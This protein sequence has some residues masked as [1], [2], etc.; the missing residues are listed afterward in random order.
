MTELS[1]K[2]ETLS[3]LQTRLKQ[4]K[5]LPQQFFTVQQWKNNPTSILKSAKSFFQNLPLIVRSSSL[6]EDTGSSSAAGAYKTLKDISHRQLSDAINEVI[7]SYDDT[8]VLN[9]ILLQ[10]MLKDVVLSGAAFSHDPNNGS[11]YLIVNWYVGSDTSFVT[12][13]QGGHIWRQAQCA[14]VDAPESISPVILLLK[15]LDKIFKQTPLDIEFA[16]S[17][18]SKKNTLWLLQCRPLIIQFDCET[19]EEQRLR[20]QR[21]RDKVASG[22]HANPLLLG[23]KTIYG[24][25]PD[26]NPAEIIGLRP[27]PLALSLY[28]ELITDSI[29]AYQRHNYGYRNLRSYPL[30]PHFFGLPYIDVRISF[31]SFI[32]ADLNETTAEKLVNYYIDCLEKEPSL[33]DKVEFEIVNSCYTLDLPEKLKK[34]SEKGFNTDEQLSIAKSLRKLTNGIIHRNHGLWKADAKKLETLQIRRTKIIASSADSIEKI[35]WLIEDCK[36]YGTLPFAGLA[37]VGFV[38]IQML[39]SLVHV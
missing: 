11:P 26:W 2:A 34:L 28:R 24:V 15:E 23:K 9:Q 1:T 7:E 33:H 18:H 13:G 6:N 20:L 12:G 22:M 25:M 31:N 21:I 17:N 5:I 14:P 35:Y 36:R 10:P 30:M 19:G 3:S 32:P 4:A 27:K 29:W 37:R 39:K 16:I 38:A 8:K